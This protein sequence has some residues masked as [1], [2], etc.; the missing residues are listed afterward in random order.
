MSALGEKTLLAYLTDPAAC[1]WLTRQGVPEDI[2]PTP[3]MRAVVV[4]ALQHYT[5]TGKAV[6]AAVLREEYGEAL[7]VAEV[8]LDFEPEESVQWALDALKSSYIRKEA[9]AFTTEFGEA[10]TSD[11][12]DRVD[13]VSEFAGRLTA[14]ALSVQPRQTQID[15]RESGREMLAEYDYVAAN[16]HNVI[17]T[18]IGWPNDNGEMPID[19]Y[20]GGVR[21]GELC[22]FAAPSGQGK[23]Y[24]L[25]DIA[26][27][28]WEA[29]DEP[30]GLFTLE[31]SIAM[32]QGRIACLALRL[33][34]TE[35]S[36]GRLTD[37]ERA[38]VEAWVNDVL[39]KSPTPLYIFSPNQGLRTPQT[40]VQAAR[41]HEVQHLI[42]D[43]LTF[44]HPDAIKRNQSM[45]YETRDKLHDFKELV[46]TGDPISLLLAHQ[47]S[48]E[49]EKEAAK[50]G[51]LQKWHMADSSEVE[52]TADWA[53]TH[54]Q[55]MDDQKTG[56]GKLQAVKAR[57]EKLR[58]W[59]TIW[60]PF[61]GLIKIR[62]EIDLSAF[63]TPGGTS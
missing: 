16:R 1:A 60:Q 38:D 31:N 37:E 59:D 28:N 5:N 48:R 42:V 41:A 56:R 27:R 35:W 20:T 53:F 25:A 36:R 30:V 19:D 43:Q 51:F 15:L 7:E 40:I 45:T 52:R 47:I 13:V 14:L 4:F 62:A 8:D 46:S 58:S 21:P 33:D 17:G 50:S 61:T 29:Q 34:A 22:V 55:S 3:S 18:R 9:Q 11:G 24:A 23:S 44:V 39:V 57:R 10:I 32:T 6:T 2:I 49:G 63:A 12:A 54:Y 26:R